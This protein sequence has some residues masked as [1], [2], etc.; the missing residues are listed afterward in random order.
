MSTNNAKPTESK[1]SSRSPD[2]SKHER[3]SSSG[4]VPADRSAPPSSSKSSRSHSSKH[5]K[6]GSSSKPS[7]SANKTR[8]LVDPAPN[9]TL[10]EK[11]QRVLN[12]ETHIVSYPGTSQYS[13]GA[14]SACGLAAL[15]AIRIALDKSLQGVTGIDLLKHL[16]LLDT[17]FVGYLRW[18]LNLA[19]TLRTGCNCYLCS[20][21]E[22]GTSRA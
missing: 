7:S 14:P 18:G 6:S 11:I 2:K 15:N 3:R 21:V 17:H 19:L 10:D 22:S 16:S 13:Q 1:S 4:K 12:G 9:L 8:L 20:L 5:S